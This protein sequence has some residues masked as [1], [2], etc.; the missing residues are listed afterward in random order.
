[1]YRSTRN[2]R[3]NLFARN[4]DGSGNEERLTVGEVNQN[5]QSISPD[6]RTLVFIVH[7][8]DLWHM[9]L[10]G[11]AKPQ[12]FLATPFREQ[13]AAFSADG[14]W[15]AYSSDES[16]RAEIYAQPFP[17]G[18]RKVQIS[19]DGGE[20][21]RWTPSGELFYRVGTRMMMTRVTT[22]PDLTVGSTELVFD[23][24]QFAP[25]T[26]GYDVSEDGRRLLMVKEND[27]S[28]SATQISVVL[29]WTRELVRKVSH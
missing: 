18:G 2:G 15:L 22:R 3:L 6:G 5:P 20:D 27:Q 14:T 10:A 16:G 23:G 1:V 12:P 25:S 28:T 29:N 4:A 13:G 9:P 17:S 26:Y 7:G 24:P 21:P 11:N 8:P 19:R